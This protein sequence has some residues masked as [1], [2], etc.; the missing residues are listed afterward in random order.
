MNRILDLIE[1]GVFTQ[2]VIAVALLGVCCYLWV[3]QGEV[4]ESLK[5]CFLVVLGFFF[6]TEISQTIIKFLIE[7]LKRR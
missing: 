2:R 4:P 3:A 6:S 5:S 1:K 7:E